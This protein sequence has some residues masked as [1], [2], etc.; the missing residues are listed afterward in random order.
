MP[1]QAK[2]TYIT[3]EEYL[4]LERQTDYKNEYFAGEIFAM[5]GASEEH[6]L[7]SGNVFAEL[8]VQL[9]KR[10]CKVYNNDMRVKVSPTGLYTYPDIVAVCGQSR[11]DDKQKDTLLNPT[12]IIEVLS[13]STED[14][15]RGDKFDKHYRTI[16][17][18]QEY[19]LIAQEKCHIEHRIRQTN[20][21]WLVSKLNHFSD[22]LEL[23]SIQCSMV[24]SDIYHKVF[25]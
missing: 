24:L 12:V 1:A 11:F 20:D 23:R 13:P 25:E 18:L 5:S 10:P 16:D 9:K 6:N 19:V 21:Q 22:T 2:T 4:S 14:Y 3:I 7:I 15:D 17:S 8:H